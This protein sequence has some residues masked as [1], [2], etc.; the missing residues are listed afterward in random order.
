MWEKGQSGNP[1]GRKANDRCLTRVLRQGL[2]QKDAD[3]NRN[4]D[5]IAEKVM[6]LARQGERWAVEFIAE[7]VEGKPVQALEHSGPE[8]KAIAFTLVIGEQDDDSGT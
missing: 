4:I 6:S 2:K 7:R 1:K 3:G 5:V 8:G